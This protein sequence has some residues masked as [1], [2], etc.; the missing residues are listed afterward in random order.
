MLRDVNH[1]AVVLRPWPTEMDFATMF[2]VV[3]FAA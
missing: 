2:D 1:A 3:L